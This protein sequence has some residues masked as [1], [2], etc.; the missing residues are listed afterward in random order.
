[1]KIEN[2]EILPGLSISNIR[3]GITKEEL[4]E[5]IGKD[6][7][8]ND[9][10][11]TTIIT[12][13]NAGF[14]ISAEKKRINQIGVWGDFQGKYKDIIGIGST[15]EDV[16]KHIGEYDNEWDT[17]G[18][19]NDKGICFEL[20]DTEDDDKWDEL[21]APIEIIFVYTED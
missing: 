17:Y 10:K 20:G 19:V 3:L 16:K 8:Q 4:I 14:W 2:G 1:M 9:S 7:E 5:L 15:L 12:V 21:T 11:Y 13:E 6:Y 18:V